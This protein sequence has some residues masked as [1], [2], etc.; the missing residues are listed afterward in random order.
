MGPLKATTKNYFRIE[1]FVVLEDT[2]TQPEKQIIGNTVQV[3]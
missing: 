2:L 3:G 1:E